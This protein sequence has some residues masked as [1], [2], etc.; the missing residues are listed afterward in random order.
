MKYRNVN[1]INR[2][3]NEI[4]KILFKL[5]SITFERLNCTENKPIAKNSRNLEQR[6]LE[7]T[8]LSCGNFVE[9][10]RINHIRSAAIVWLINTYMLLVIKTF[11][12]SFMYVLYNVVGNF[13]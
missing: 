10:D 5:K 12:L 4:R 6:V 9:S 8:S 13:F 3:V 7:Y 11:Y 2:L 1:A